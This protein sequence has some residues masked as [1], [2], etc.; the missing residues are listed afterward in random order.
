MSQLPSIPGSPLVLNIYEG[1][2]TQAKDNIL[3]GKLDLSRLQP[4][5]S[6]IQ[7]S[8]EIDQSGVIEVYAFDLAGDP[9]RRREISAVCDVGRLSTQDLQRML[10]QAEKLAG[11]CR[12]FCL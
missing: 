3:V 7:I 4:R 1:R 10:K 12:Y 5:P 11:E 2:S 9:R 8:I 6:Q